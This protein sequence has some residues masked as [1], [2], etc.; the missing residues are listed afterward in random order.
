MK[1]LIRDTYLPWLGRKKKM[2]K[3]EVCITFGIPRSTVDHYWTARPPLEARRFLED[4]YDDYGAYS[5]LEAKDEQ[6]MYSRVSLGLCRDYSLHDIQ[7]E[8]YRLW[9]K[10]RIAYDKRIE[11]EDI[12]KHG[13]AKVNKHKED[14]LNYGK[15][16]VNKHKEEV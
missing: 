7:E 14:I 3:K 8:L 6:E 1:I 4:L 2:S 10:S 5:I 15:D 11:A 13:K 12:R 9:T 16:E